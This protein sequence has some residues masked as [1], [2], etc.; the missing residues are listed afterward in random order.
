M[1]KL[2]SGY[3]KGHYKGID[4]NII[5]VEEINNQTKNKWFW[6]IGDDGGQDWFNSKRIAIEAV[7]DYINNSNQ[8]NL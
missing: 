2:Y 3:Y 4:F 8:T 1:K 5:K 7:K 6:L